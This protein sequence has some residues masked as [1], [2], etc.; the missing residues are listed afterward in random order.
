YHLKVSPDPD[1]KTLR[2]DDC[3]S[4]HPLHVAGAMSIY[5][6]MHGAARDAG[7]VCSYEVTDTQ[8]VEATIWSPNRRKVVKVSAADGQ[9]HGESK[10]QS[11]DGDQ[12]RGLVDSLLKVYA[13]K[14]SGESEVNSAQTERRG[15]T[16]AVNAKTAPSGQD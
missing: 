3:A 2:C 6:H 10:T 9:L 8:G 11:A 1:D 14:R 15:R 5:Q 7:L 4:R 12:V 16:G 13:S